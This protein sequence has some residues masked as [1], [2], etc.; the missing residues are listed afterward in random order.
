LR[1]ACKNEDIALGNDD[2]A[3]QITFMVTP[4]PTIKM[5]FYVFSETMKRYRNE[6]NINLSD[7]KIYSMAFNLLCTYLLTPGEFTETT[8][9]AYAAKQYAKA[10]PDLKQ[11][12]LKVLHIGGAHHT[13]TLQRIISDTLFNLKMENNIHVNT[14]WD[15]RINENDMSGP[16]LFFRNQIPY[17]ERLSAV[18]K[19]NDDITLDFRAFCSRALNAVLLY[20]DEI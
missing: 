10:R 8:E 18:R 14:R 2:R 6:G 20:L 3:D 19:I 4:D 16:G 15:P 5:A 17:S 7:D 11:R 13:S 1:L 9:I 12:C